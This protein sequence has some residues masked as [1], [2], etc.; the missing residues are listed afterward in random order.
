[1]ISFLG[2]V[3]AQAYRLC[4]L[5]AVKVETALWTSADARGLGR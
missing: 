5:M 2:G 3:V 4:S 1:M